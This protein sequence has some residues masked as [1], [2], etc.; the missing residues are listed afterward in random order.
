MKITEPKTKLDFESYY[1][2]RW[3]ILRKPW[4]QPKG[5]EKDDLEDKSIHLVACA[6][7][8]VIG[9]ARAHFNSANE[10]QIRYMA[11]EQQYRGKGIG[12]KLLAELEKRVRQK[13]ATHIT[14]NARKTAVGFYE[15]H[16]YE[17]VAK[18]HTLY[19]SIEHFKMKKNLQPCPI[20]PQKSSHSS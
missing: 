19:D 3:R 6:G 5:S 12:G 1:D 15:N 8:I 7:S 14:L 17:I 18:S 4:N 13:D 11:I 2:L 9:V 16:D 10:A 20:A